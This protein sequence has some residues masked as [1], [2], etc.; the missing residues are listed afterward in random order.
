MMNKKKIEECNLIIKLSNSS[1]P[2]L[3]NRYW[4]KHFV[5]KIPLMFNLYENRLLHNDF[6]DEVLLDILESNEILAY[7][8]QSK[9]FSF[10]NSTKNIS[11]FK[12]FYSYKAKVLFKVTIVVVI[13]GALLSKENLCKVKIFFSLYNQTIKKVFKYPVLRTVFILRKILKLAKNYKSLMFKKLHL[14][15]LRIY[16]IF[17]FNYLSTL[18]CIVNEKFDKNKYDLLFSKFESRQIKLLYNRLL[19]FWFS[20]FFKDYFLLNNI[21]SQ[22]NHEY[23]IDEKSI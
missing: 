9:I 6:L 5:Y 8:F 15:Y 11:I 12:I 3:E 7:N 22:Y 21:L 18:N 23:S 17:F 1:A 13:I 20:I 16:K 14:Y 10:Y 4:V 2:I 19:I